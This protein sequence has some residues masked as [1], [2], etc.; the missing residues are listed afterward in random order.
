MNGP[1]TSIEIENVIKKL[2]KNRSLGLDGFIG[3]YYQTF[4]EELMHIFLVSSKKLQ[5]KENSQT[6]SMRP[7]SPLSPNKRPQ[8]HY[9]N[10]TDEYRCK[11]PQ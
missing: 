11:N 10:I 2:P 7:S 8:K 6:H 1:V 4:R 9:T 5:R 3:K